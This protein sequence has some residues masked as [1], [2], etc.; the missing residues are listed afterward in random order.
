MINLKYIFRYF[1]SAFF[2]IALFAG[3]VYSGST[4][5][6]AYA[7]VLQQRIEYLKG[8]YNLVGIS[9][10]AEVPGQ[11]VWLGTAGISHVNVNMD[12]GMVFDV[13]SVTKNLDRKSVV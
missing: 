3:Q 6:T 9:A 7:R 12:T 5:D 1:L 8:A 10:A 13:G 4:F 2:I 11:G